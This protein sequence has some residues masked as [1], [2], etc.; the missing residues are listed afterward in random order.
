MHSFRQLCLQPGQGNPFPPQD[1]MGNQDALMG[2]STRPPPPVLEQ[3]GS[4][5]E[6]RAAKPL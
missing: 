3:G 2:G 5:V 6:S 1:S 4:E